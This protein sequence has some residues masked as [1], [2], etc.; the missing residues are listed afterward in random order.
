M[1]FSTP[2]RTKTNNTCHNTSVPDKPRP[3]ILPP[4][5]GAA[6]HVV[7]ACNRG[8]CNTA[9]RKKSSPRRSTGPHGVERV[10][11]LTTT[12]LDPPA[13]TSTTLLLDASSTT[14]TND[15][16][17][18]P[19][20]TPPEETS[21]NIAPVVQDPPKQGKHARRKSKSKQGQDKKQP[22][23]KQPPPSTR[24]TIKPETNWIQVSNIPVRTCIR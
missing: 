10:R 24:T 20:D 19:L 18:V 15:P 17:S 4:F 5:F 12:A 8:F 1:D 16:S 11:W 21:T 6:S 3:S 14:A 7:R 23:K 22:Q 2:M 9:R 13:P